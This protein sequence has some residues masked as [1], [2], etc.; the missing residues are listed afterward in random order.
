MGT[1][2]NLEKLYRS[3]MLAFYA[4]PF[5]QAT[6][7]ELILSERTVGCGK[8]YACDCGRRVHCLFLPFSTFVLHTG[9]VQIAFIHN[10]KNG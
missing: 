2:L 3:V 7:R 9:V 10:D 5:Q 1:V 6:V 4:I 8:D